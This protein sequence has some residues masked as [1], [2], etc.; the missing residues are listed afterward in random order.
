MRQQ[1]SG[2]ESGR[3]SSSD[4]REKEDEE[5]QKERKRKVYKD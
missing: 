2:K 3:N 1:E 5:K 4:I